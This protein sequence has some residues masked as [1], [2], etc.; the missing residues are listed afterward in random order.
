MAGGMFSVKHLHF[1]AWKAIV[2]MYEYFMCY[3]ITCL[4][5]SSCYIKPPIGLSIVIIQHVRKWGFLISYFIA[6][7]RFSFEVETE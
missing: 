1:K 4:F 5:S 2:V 6:T 3:H 7:S